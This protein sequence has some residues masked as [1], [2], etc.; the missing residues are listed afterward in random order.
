MVNQNKTFSLR[1]KRQAK[2]KK[3][4]KKMKEE[5]KVFPSDVR[6]TVILLPRLQSLW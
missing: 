4:K 3:K 2:K 1:I 6:R 5:K